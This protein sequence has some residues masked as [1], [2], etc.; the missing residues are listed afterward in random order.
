LLPV[1][2]ENRTS[3]TQALSLLSPLAVLQGC[4]LP[5]IVTRP[6]IWDTFAAECVGYQEHPE[7]FASTLWRLLLIGTLPPRTQQQHGA[8]VRS[9]CV[10]FARILNPSLAGNHMVPSDLVWNRRSEEGSAA[11]KG[12]QENDLKICKGVVFETDISTQIYMVAEFLCGR[13]GWLTNH[14]E[15]I[16]MKSMND[17]TW[18]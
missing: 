10:A 18:M 15:P 3:Y 13:W 4:R 5:K 7:T 8:I 9:D 12:P 14:T 2:P 11:E 17:E 16:F 1:L 6:L